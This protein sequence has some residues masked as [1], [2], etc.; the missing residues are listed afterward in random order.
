MARIISLFV[1]IVFCIGLCDSVYFCDEN[2]I[3]QTI[4]L[5]EKPQ[6]PSTHKAFKDEE[7]INGT[8][9]LFKPNF[10]KW[11]SRAHRC[12]LH[13][14]IIKT[15][16]DCVFKFC[17]NIKPPEYEHIIEA[18]DPMTCLEW[19]R[20]DVCSMCLTM[21]IGGDVVYVDIKRGQQLEK[22]RFKQK[23]KSL[24][25]TEAYLKPRYD[26]VMMGVA[27]WEGRI[28]NCEISEGNVY[29][30]MPGNK[31]VSSWGTLSFT[32]GQDEG[33]R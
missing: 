20:S 3:V 28:Q 26:D 25:F 4:K 30:Q 9:Y 24:R 13:T 12:R 7:T 14:T 31:I 17:S 11:E 21:D 16:T 8:A 33:I 5:E 18:I 23:G 19:I 32:G 29:T 6:C 15:A 27:R 22:C 10:K 1:I 2:E